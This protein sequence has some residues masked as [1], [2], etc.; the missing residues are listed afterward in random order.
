VKIL[1]ICLFLCLILTAFWSCSVRKN[2]IISRNYHGTTTHYNFYFNARERV[3]QASATL[4]D[5]H[6]DKYDRVLSIF[7]IGDLN[8]AKGV[9]PD[10]DEAIKKA[11]IAISR[12]SMDVKGRK[13]NLIMERNRW[14]P[15]CYLVIGQSQFYKHDFW[16]AIE[17]FQFISSEY[18]NDEIRPEALIWLTRTYLELGKTTDAEYLLDYLKAD[19]EFPVK[20]RGHYHA[21]LAQYHLMKKDVSRAMSA[22]EVAASSSGKKDDRARYY[23]ILGQLYQKSDTLEKAFSAYD[24][25]VK[26]NPPYEMAFNARINRA[27]CYD[28]GSGSGETVKRELQK[29]LKDIKNSEFLDQI[30]FAL[31]GVAK[32][33]N[34]EPLSVELLNKS[35]RASS[36]NTTQ[37]ARSYLE[38]GDIYLGRPDYIPAAAYY[39][40]CLTNITN[41]HP[42]YF[43]IQSKRNSLDRLVKN[44]KIIMAEDSLLSLADMSPEEREAAVAKI[45]EAEDAEKERLKKENEEKQKLEEQQIQ[46]EKQLM[47]QPRAVNQPSSATQGAWYFYNQSAISFGF[48]EF[49]KRWGNR[50]LED[51]W[52]RSEKDIVTDGVDTSSTDSL[53]QKQGGLKD[54]IA[55]LDANARKSAYL[56][57]IPQSPEQIS[58]SHAKVAEAYYNCGVIYK[59]QLQ[60]YKESV[61]SFER[62]DERYPDNKYKLPSYYNLYRI[63]ILMKD[64]AKADYYKNFILNNYPESDYARLILNPDFFKDMKRKSEVLEVFYENTYRAYLNRQYDQVIER[65]QYADESF[66][67]NNKLAPKF[68]YL[69]AMAIGKTRS[70]ENFQFELEDIIRR[71]PK[72]SV[73]IQARAILDIIQNKN[74]KSTVKDTAAVDTSNLID[75]FARSAKFVFDLSAMHFFV[76]IY[77]NAAVDASELT[78]KIEAFNNIENSGGSLVVNGGNIDLKLRYIAVMSFPSKDE[79]MMYYERIMGEPGLLDQFDPE[80]VKMFVISQ[81]N[82]TELTRTKDMKAYSEFFKSKY[83]E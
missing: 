29:M 24:K 25:V 63:W 39:D 17:T 42:E 28:A 36:G 76:I 78:R 79:G 64:S 46:E 69:K 13:D 51:H 53:A 2:N 37:L 5:A 71:Y 14:I 75:P 35:V 6:E 68:A 49:A 41:D 43:D 23:F 7:K 55:G 70:L 16:S 57:M 81:S 44:L 52:R 61:R 60:D 67:A 66:P 15:R 80:L 65:K 33:E 59:E 77:P 10:L 8:K 62:L 32:Q 47:S 54:S 34:N 72:D 48:N 11:S 40:S 9:F 12:H 22:L 27:R 20:Q 18:K 56:A 83:L 26:L 58:A 82:L 4:A 19:K 38:L 74:I 45:V 50:K 31:A 21:V 1:R 73:S 3:K 30:Y